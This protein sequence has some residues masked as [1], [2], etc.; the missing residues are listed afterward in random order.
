MN[1]FNFM[2][3][4]QPPQNS[5]N[6]NNEEV[7]QTMGEET[8]SDAQSVVQDQCQNCAPL[9]QE[10]EE[11][12]LSWQRALADYKN[13]QKETT[14]RRSEWAQMSSEQIL[15]EFI[16]VYDN[17]KKAF[18][19]VPQLSES[20]NDKKMKNWVDGIG[21][22][23]K[24]FKDVLMSN[25]VTELAT[26]GEMFDTKFH[27]AVGEEE[28]EEKTPGTIIR[29]AEGGYMMGQKVIKP[30]KVIIATKKV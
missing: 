15:Q 12:K 11:Y 22:I 24:M 9:Q 17:F 3:R 8:A 4:K 26:T 2:F 10:A 16:P 14:E 5:A 6:M 25:G 27:D 23:M 21:Y 7:S 18:A 29:E 13:L 19:C 1:L 20:E 30:A 28:N